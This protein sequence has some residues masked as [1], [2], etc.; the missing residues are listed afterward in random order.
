MCWGIERWTERAVLR[1]V[2][3][4]AAGGAKD[5]EKPRIRLEVEIVRALT[6]KVTASAGTAVDTHPSR[7]SG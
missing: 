7:G 2:K 5:H 3:V 6:V 4:T 1:R